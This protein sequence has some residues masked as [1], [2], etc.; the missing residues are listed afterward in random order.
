M[1]VV[2]TKT[3]QSIST[4]NNSQ[5]EHKKIL[6]VPTKEIIKKEKEIDND[7]VLINLMLLGC[8]LFPLKED[9]RIK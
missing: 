9:N 6:F 5:K 4:T 2:I 1:V 8:K 3:E 7:G